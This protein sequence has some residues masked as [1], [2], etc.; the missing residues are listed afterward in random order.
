MT[1]KIQKILANAGLGSRRELETWLINGRISVN[2]KIAKLGD[3]AGENDKLEVDG[4]LIRLN[5]PQLEELPSVL[6]YHKPNGEVCTRSDPEGRP[7][8]FENLPR[9]RNKRWI[10]VGRLDLNTAGLLLFTTDGELANRLMHPSFEIEREYAVRVWGEVN[11]TILANLS[12]GVMLEDGMARFT[13]IQ[14]AGGEG[15]NHWY[16]V[17]LTEGKN[18]EVRRLWESQ[19]VTVSRLIRIRYG[20]IELPR[21]LRQGATRMLAPEVVSQLLAKVNLPVANLEEDHT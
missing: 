6:L 3:R 2:G 20:D 9:L 15:K 1:E 10:M 4:R 13:S 12:T 21:D 8:V 14:D 19:G 5:K 17:I 11:K 18:R 16:H 7:V